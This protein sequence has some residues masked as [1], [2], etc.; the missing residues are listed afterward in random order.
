MNEHNWISVKERLPYRTLTLTQ[1]KVALVDLDI[2][3][4]VSQWK[5][6]AARTGKH[7]IRWYA[8]R[9]TKNKDGNYRLLYL[10]HVV[11]PCPKGL[12]PDHINGDSLDY[13]RQNL[14]LATNQQNCANSERK[15][16]AIRSSRYKGV[17]FHNNK[18]EATIRVNLVKK[19]LGRFSN[20]EDAAAAYNKAAILFFGE[21]SR[22][23]TIA[24]SKREDFVP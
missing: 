3:D 4:Q 19:Y 5:W 7:R 17:H 14:L 2:F 10:H 8:V 15:G 1:G 22:I 9:N 24:A 20:E 12:M 16:G 21:F 13:R 23:N 11:L 18:W 6:S